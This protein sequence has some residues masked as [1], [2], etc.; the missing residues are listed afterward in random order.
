MKYILYA[1]KSS[2]DKGRQILSL[3][4]QVDTMQRIAEELGLTIAKVIT[5]SKSAKMPHNRPNFEEML[6]LIER[7]EA[8]GILCWKLDRLSRNPIDSGQIQ[9]FLQQGTIQEI[10]T[11]ERKYL[12]D[13]NALIFNVE[14]GM[15][16]QYILDLSKNIHR[17]IKTKLE[18]GGYP[19]YAKIGYINDTIAK[20]V[21]PD[22]ERT[23]YIRRAFELYATGSH[24]V[25]D[26]SDILFEEGFRSRGGHKYHKSKIHKILQDPFYYGTMYVHGKYYTGN[27]TPLISK[28]LFDKVQDVFAEQN[29]SRYK[30][31]FFPLRG[32]MTCDVCGLP[33]YRHEEE[34]LYLL[35]LHQWKEIVRRTQKISSK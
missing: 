13:D 33:S 2:E 23:R 25:K 28:E 22:K 29:R 18:K 26:V 27:H 15:A 12:P 11:A 19:N 32:F 16:N 5:E 35:L 8:S 10:Q 20:T 30:K 6:S 14:S 7:G 1:R 4:S 34:G 21:I 17:G 24:S 31:H 3:E 9:W